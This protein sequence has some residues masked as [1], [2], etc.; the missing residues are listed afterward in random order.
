MNLKFK[1]A[2]LNKQPKIGCFLKFSDADSMEILASIGY[3]FCIIDAEH[4]GFAPREISHLLRAAQLY[5][6][7]CI[8]RTPGL[9]PG[10]ILSALDA[11][12]SGIQVPNIDTATQ[13]KELVSSA[14]YMPKGNRGF[15]PTT[16]AGGFGVKY[17][18]AE[19]AEIANQSVVTVAHCETKTSVE[20]LD[21][22]LKQKDLDVI[23]VGPMDMS[24]SYGFLGQLE[25]P[26][27]KTAIESS[28]S[29]ISN[30]GKI[31]GFMCASSKIEYYYA[32][33]VR[34]FIVGSDQGFM[35]NAAKDALS[36]AKSA[37]V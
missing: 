30:A 6:M 12:A 25:Q 29:K 28:L 3:D 2:L 1:T 21:S 18:P 33:G 24:Q 19:Y 8:V 10:F 27:V 20:N 31:A 4:A 23:F 26:E 13:A 36:N 35:A 15:S 37:L 17:K 11:G 22:I 14:Y 7:P 9:N 32:L 5:D 16:R 34:Y